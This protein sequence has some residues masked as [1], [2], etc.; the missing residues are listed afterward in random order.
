MEEIYR[1]SYGGV[2]FGVSMPSPGAP[3]SQY[4]EVFTSLEG[5]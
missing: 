1:A 5:L 2:R 3:A 4:L